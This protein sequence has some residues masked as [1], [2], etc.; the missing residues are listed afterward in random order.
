MDAELLFELAAWAVEAA[1]VVDACDALACVE[2]AC[3]A[4]AWVD[5]ELACLVVACFVVV[6][7]VVAARLFWI[8]LVI[9]FWKAILFN[10]TLSMLLSFQT[11]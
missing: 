4:L 6:C 2:L 5:V 7:L 3:V 11:T 10:H 9:V 8:L 1:C